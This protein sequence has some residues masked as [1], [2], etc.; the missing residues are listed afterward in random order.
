MLNHTVPQRDAQTPTNGAI[1]AARMDQALHVAGLKQSIILVT[2]G[3]PNCGSDRKYAD[4]VTRVIDSDVTQY[5]GTVLGE[6]DQAF[7]Q[8]PSIRTFVVGFYGDAAAVN[9]L[10]LENMGYYGGDRRMGCGS[11][12][13][14]CY[15]P[16]S[17]GGPTCSMIL[18]EVA[19]QIVGE[20]SQEC[21]N[22]CEGGI[23]PPGEAC[24]TTEIN[25]APHCA[26]ATP[27]VGDS[28][29]GN[30]DRGG[31]CQ[32]ST[33]TSRQGAGNRLLLSSAALAATLLTVRRRRRRARVERRE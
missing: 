19:T 9:T 28:C 4:L 5:P 6:L 16:V 21:E 24:V 15:F 11:G 13:T 25:P 3:D 2:D 18:D 27:C 7:R 26:P 30:R 22:T 20:S 32:C 29:G 33:G 8:S 31:G 10:N 23:C 1:H 17:V 14:H 12:G